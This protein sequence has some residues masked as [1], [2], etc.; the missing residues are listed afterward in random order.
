[1]N[2]NENV[3]PPVEIPMAALSADALLGM[4]DAFILREGTDYGV[5]EVSHES[6]VKQIEKQLNR[7][8]IKIVFDPNTDTATL[9]TKNEW[10][11]LV[12]N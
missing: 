2:D 9:I 8:D 6:K 5:N 4:I 3:Q 1:M 7:G 11:K 10:K 12:K